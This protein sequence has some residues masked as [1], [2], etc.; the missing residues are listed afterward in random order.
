YIDTYRCNLH[1]V[2][3]Q[4]RTAR[5]PFRYAAAG[6]L[7]HAY[8]MTIHKAQGATVECALVLA[9]ESLTREHAYTALSRAT[10]GTDI[11]LETSDPEIEAHA[12]AP[13]PE[14]VARLRLPIGRSVSQQPAID[15]SPGALVP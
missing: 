5:I 2:D 3:D 9:D 13:P 8:A 14:A 10:R 1:S 7:T 4:Q 11:F 12:P 6:D 15:R